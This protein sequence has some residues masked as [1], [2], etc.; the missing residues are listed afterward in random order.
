MLLLLVRSQSIKLL[1]PL[2]L[3]LFPSTYLPRLIQPLKQ[4]FLL[5][6]LRLIDSLASERMK[7][8]RLSLP[9]TMMFPL[10]L[11]HLKTL[12]PV[13]RL[14]KQKREKPPQ[15]IPMLRMP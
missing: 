13:S 2:T 4:E 11:I 7:P 10:L 1:K 5:P 6:L 15:L 14:P 9:V 8:T 12:K 3:M